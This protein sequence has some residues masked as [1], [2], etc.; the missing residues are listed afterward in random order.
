MLQTQSRIQENGDWIVFGVVIMLGIATAFYLYSLDKYSLVYFG[1]SASHMLIARK[2]VDWMEPGLQQIGTVWLPLPHLMLMPFALIDPLFTTGF[3]GLAVSLP[4]LAITA[5]LLYK[6]ARMHLVAGLGYMAFVAALLYVTNS[7]ILY[8]GLTAMTEA[9][10]MLFFVAAAYFMQK[11][12]KNSEQLHS[13]ALS[14][15]FVALAT[16]CRYEGWILPLF[17]V[18]FAIILVFRD[19]KTDLR[20][21]ILVVLLSLISFA[22]IVF[23]LAYNQ[24]GYGNALEFAEAQYYSAASQALGREYR[25]TL[26]LQPANVI[27]IYGATAFV[28]YGPI[29]LVAALAGYILH[30]KIKEGK[31]DRRVLYIFLILPPV[32]TIISL[33]IGIGEMT[34]WFN[35]RFV[36]LLAPLVIMLAAVVFVQN[37]PDKIK[38]NRKL[39]AAVIGGLF[40]FQ[41]S[42]P[43]FGAVPTYLD[44]R[45]GFYY[46]SSPFAAQAAEALNSMYDGGTIMIVTGSAQEHRVMVIGGIPLRQYDEIL[47]SSMWKQSF[48]EPWSHHKWIVI[49]KDPDFDG[50]SPVKYWQ[51]RR[52]QLDEHYKQVYENEYY[53]ILTLK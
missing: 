23:W 53:E 34:Y 3:A 37:L 38:K 6:I 25:E 30:K 44:A 27:S 50:T 29:L 14:S 45:G 4:C 49:S 13:L 52:D 19:S 5:A 18:P 26:F 42:V 24:Y 2:V 31:R 1:D 36:I 11:W 47:E 17:V 12:L 40:I 22:G 9:P 10:F 20:K 41:V 28:V 8:I 51:D 43:T 16:L 15:I 39:I 46:K 21:R 33:L 7:N 48:H 32:F 35:S